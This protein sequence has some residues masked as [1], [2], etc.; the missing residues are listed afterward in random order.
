MTTKDASKTRILIHSVLFLASLLACTIANAQNLPPMKWSGDVRYRHEELRVDGRTDRS[1]DRLRARLGV[2][3]EIDE[4]WHAIARI[5]TG[6]SAAKSATSSNQTLSNAGEDKAIW[7]N[8]GYLQWKPQSEIELRLGKMPNMW[9][10]PVGQQMVFDEE[11]APEG[12]SGQWTK[13]SESHDIFVSAH[14]H[15]LVERD[16]AAG[17]ADSTDAGFFG[18]QGGFKTKGDRQMT[19]TLGVFATTN[20]AGEPVVAGRGFGGN[21]TRTIGATQ[22]YAHNYNLGVASIEW[23]CNQVPLRLGAQVARN[24][25]LGKHNIAGALTAQWGQ[26]KA[27]HDWLVSYTLEY[28]EQDAVFGIVSD[29]DINE[30]AADSKGHIIQGKYALSD[31]VSASLTQYFFDTQVSAAAGPVDYRRT[32]LD[33]IAKF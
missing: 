30:V 13:S 33:L 4:Q 2:D 27:K 10:Q 21:S 23:G 29:S 16:A 24:F 31:K 19:A 18:A 1:R 15:W 14:A 32:M 11:Y 22:V 20:L 26:V 6:E 8:W 17:V 28:I 5:G 7:L 3:A 12:L 25:D 9:W